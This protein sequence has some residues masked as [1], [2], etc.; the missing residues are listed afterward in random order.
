[1]Q[2]VWIIF[3]FVFLLHLTCLPY[4]NL[5]KLVLRIL[6]IGSEAHFMV[7][8]QMLGPLLMFKDRKLL[9]KS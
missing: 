1:M 4:T 9:I 5:I 7:L 6:F 3:G 2:F 8:S